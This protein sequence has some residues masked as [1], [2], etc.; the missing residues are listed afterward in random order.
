MDMASIKHR[1][2]HR[3][4]KKPLHSPLA[5]VRQSRSSRICLSISFVADAAR[6]SLGVKQPDAVFFCERPRPSHRTQRDVL[7]RCFPFPTNRPV[8]DEA[9]ARTVS[10]ILSDPASFVDNKSSSHFGRKRWFEPTINPILSGSYK[11]RHQAPRLPP[12]T[13]PRLE[14]GSNRDRHRWP[15]NRP[16]NLPTKTSQPG[17]TPFCPD[18]APPKLFYYFFP[19]DT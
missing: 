4:I 14:L 6:G 3:R 15:Q 19:P 5:E 9:T 2:Q 10:G 18:T 13:A 16:L 17:Q 7:K 1:H 8:P 11:K 12:P